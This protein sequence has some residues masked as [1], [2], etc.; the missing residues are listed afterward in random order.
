MKKSYEYIRL[1][2]HCVCA[3]RSRGEKVFVGDSLEWNE[4]YDDMESVTCEWCNDE[5]DKS[6]LSECHF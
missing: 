2:D 5:F 3:I 6:E 4:K 1:C